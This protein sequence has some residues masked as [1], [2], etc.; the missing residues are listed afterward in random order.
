MAVHANVFVPPGASRSIPISILND[1]TTAGGAQVQVWITMRGDADLAIGLDAPGDTWIS[2]VGANQSASAGIDAGDGGYAAGIDNG[3]SASMG[4]IPGDS[5]SAIAIW[6]GTIPKGT[7][8]IT[9][10]GHGV[11]DL[12]VE[13]SG[14]VLDGNGDGGGVGFVDPVR[15]GT[16]NI[17]ATNPG[18]IGVGC[19]VNRDGWTSIDNGPVTIGIGA[20]DGRGGYAVDGGPV[21]TPRTGDVCWF[22]SAGPTVTGVPKPEVS[23]PGGIVIGAMSEWAQPGVSLSS[24]FN[25][26]N[27]PSLTDGGASDVHCMQIDATHA[28]AVGTSMSSPQ[29][30]GVAALLFQRDPTLTQDQ[31]VGLLQ[32]GVHSFRT[33]AP[34]FED[35]GGPGEIDAQGSLDAL[36]QMKSPTLVLPVLAAS[37]ITVSADELTAD[38]STPLTAIVELRTAGGAHRADLFNASRLAPVVKLDGSE[39]SQ[40]PPLQRRAPG[41]WVFTVTPPA[42]LGGHTLTLG[43]T[44]DGAPIVAP[45]T[46]A[47]STDVWTENYPSSVAGSCNVSR[48]GAAVGSGWWFL[49]CLALGFRR[50]TRYSAASETTQPCGSQ[51]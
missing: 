9:L 12:Y 28:V 4:M 34:R 2:P 18:L 16:I 25:N 51:M 20:L 40:L 31:I 13:G 50:W 15:E 33:G 24:I 11:A 42:G 8:A 3:S 5:H 47:I 41:V 39:L 6:Q 37:W 38:G 35:Q 1:G 17:P 36:E 19:T 22:S 7:Y 48:V 46:V 43:A 29:A 10:T 30:A 44:F 21:S 45:K 32:A 27:C 26:P 23:A 49:A 14:D